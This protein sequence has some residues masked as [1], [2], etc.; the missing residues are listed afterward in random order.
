L[1]RDLGWGQSVIQGGV[2]RVILNLGFCQKIGKIA[3]DS[4]A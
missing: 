3:L 2:P 4:N 1:G